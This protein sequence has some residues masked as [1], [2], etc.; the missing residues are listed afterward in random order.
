MLS[1][2]RQDTRSRS[3]FD[4]VLLDHG[5]YREFDRRF[6]HSYAKL[7]CALLLNDRDALYESAGELGIHNI[8]VLASLLTA[9]LHTDFTAGVATRE[10][11]VQMRSIA[12]ERFDVVINTM[13]TVPQ[14]MLLLFRVHDVLRSVVREL[15]GEVN[16]FCVLADWAARTLR[17]DA[18]EEV[19]ERT[20]SRAWGLLHPIASMA[21]AW[22]ITV[23]WL[24]AYTSY[25]SIA[26]RLWTLY[27]ISSSPLLTPLLW[28][29][30][31]A[32]PIATQPVEG[33]T[34]PQDSVLPPSLPSLQSSSS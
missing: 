22:E 23:G 31:A 25:F 32:A 8:K 19:R 18:L 6:L 4:L 17:E 20:R 29:W 7:W 15:G 12:L 5:L 27:G 16:T 1:P 13:A 2:C 24:S 9:R 11:L 3:A 10:E 14:N 34:S 28:L 33:H 30:P 21:T 26:S